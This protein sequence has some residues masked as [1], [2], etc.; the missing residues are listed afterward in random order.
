[1]SVK[2]VKEPKDC[3]PREL[4]YE[5]LYPVP[6]GGG[7][8]YR[9]K[10]FRTRREAEDFD[11]KAREALST[12]PNV[13]QSKAS[14]ITVGQLHREWLK[15]LR[16]SGGRRNDG[17]A[18]NT[19]EAYD[20]IYRSVIEP[21]WGSAPLSTITD[22]AV[23][24]WAEQGDFSSPSRKAKG[25]RQFSRLVEYAVGRYI[26]TNTVKPYLKQLPK[27][28]SSDVESHSLS[29]R[30]VLR[31]AAC[32]PEHYAEMFIFLALTGLRFGELAALRG[33]DVS[34]NRLNVRRT[35]RTVNNRITY[36]DVTK[37][38][39]RRTIPLTQLALDIAEARRRG[40]DDHLFTA[41][42]GGDLQNQ[43]VSKRAL[44]PAVSVACCAV[45]GLQGALSVSEYSGD[46][47]VYGTETEGAVK[48]FQRENGLPVT[49][50][51]DPATRQALGLADAAHDFTLQ[52][53]DSDFPEDFSL[54]SFRHTCVSLVV[55][56]GANVKAAQSFA[57]HASASMT[58]DT[59]SHLFNDDLESIAEV[60]AGIVADAQ[61]SGLKALDLK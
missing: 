16:R 3:G 27:A 57:G 33:R 22:K 9:R 59:Y 45:E 52:R 12:A 41:P 40:R 55:A 51:A 8:K 6:D 15:Y 53:G 48:R 19:L 54:H 61:D 26:A 25:V 11:R 20:G 50:S 1:M 60:L 37:G 34:G 58:L 10:K 31:I 36:A 49:G 56:A 32:S 44:K 29:M 46:F 17:T 39:E 38:G 13:D 28:E 30:Q 24:D 5:C 18:E 4:P 14:K 2:K 21:R 35:Q 23:R 47:H 7:V 42:K 43:N